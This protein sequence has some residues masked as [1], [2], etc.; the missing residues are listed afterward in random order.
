MGIGADLAHVFA[1]HGHAL[2]LVARSEG[3]LKSIAEELKAKHGVEVKYVIQDLSLENAAKHVFDRVKEMGCEVDILVNNAGVGLH[4]YFNASDLHETM[5]M[6][7]LNISSLTELTHYFLNVM[8]AQK[9]GRILNVASTA[10]FQPGPLMAVYYATKAYVL[11]FSEALFEESRKR[12]VSVTALC[13][14]PTRSEFQER[15]GMGKVALFSYACMDSRPVAEKAYRALMKNK[16]IVI[17]GFLNK[18]LSFSTRLSPRFLTTK[19]AMWL[20][21]ERK[22]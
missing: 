13:P 20:Q 9:Q 17:P 22:N 7:R 11:H 4:S 21:T 10:A 8:L 2:I 1:E 19:I 12:G 5:K 6:I 18:L 16:A 15:A 3:K 14:G